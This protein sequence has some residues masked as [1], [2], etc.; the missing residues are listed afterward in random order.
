MEYV[1]KVCS[2]CEI[3]I[4]EKFVKNFKPKEYKN[5]H[6]FCRTCRKTLRKYQLIHGGK[7]CSKCSVDKPF[8]DYPI[9]KKTYDGFDSWC[10]ECRRNYLH[11]YNQSL[12][13][14]F[15]KKLDTIRDDRRKIFSDLTIEQLVNLWNKQEGKCAISG[16]EMSHQRVK[17]QHNMTNCSVDRI[18]SSKE[19]TINNV[20]L[21]CWTV[22]R[23][24]GETSLEELL[25]WCKQ[26]VKNNEKD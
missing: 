25:K 10:K 20:Q 9:H 7:V 11:E 14:F 3:N 13:A 21:V 22:N 1:K 23:M 5:L 17:R 16:V 19:Y 12:D 8:G 15:R 24:K 6:G 2:L 26:I 18:D 4:D